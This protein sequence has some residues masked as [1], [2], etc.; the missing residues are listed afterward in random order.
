MPTNPALIKTTINTLKAFDGHPV[1][2]EALGAHIETRHGRQLTMQAIG[3]VLR[4]CRD[5]GW[6]KCR[7]DDI[8]GTLWTITEAGKSK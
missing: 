8:E 5:H 4:L 2:E 6:A 1:S 7:E 3:D